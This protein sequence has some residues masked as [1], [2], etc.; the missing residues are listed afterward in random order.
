MQRKAQVQNIPSDTAAPSRVWDHS[1]HERFYDYYAEESISEKALERFRRT[2]DGILRVLDIGLRSRTLQVADIGCGAGTQ[3]MVWAESGHD[4]HGHDVN[5]RLVG[6][7]RERAADAG[8]KIDFRVGS[9]TEL[10]WASA[11][12][13]VCIGLELL[14]HVAN[15]RACMEEFTRVLRPGGALFL[16]TTNKLCPIQAEFN[17]P[18]YSWYPAFV[19]HYFERLA[20]TTRPAV[21]NFARYPAVNWFTF[22]QLECL[23][24]QRGF[25]S[26]DRFDLIDTSD[27]GTLAK[28]I[29]SAIRAAPIL[30]WLGQLGTP[31]TIIL[32]TKM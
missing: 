6:L 32:A 20:I 24:A 26:L 10:P 27:K 14:E 7:G 3:S 5:E 17:L 15:W 13:D 29:V 21:A 2:R 23:L 19:K 1:T 9:A 12:M 11:S 30:R 4:V 22:H 25:R 31:G 8:H 16:T 28:L 18:F